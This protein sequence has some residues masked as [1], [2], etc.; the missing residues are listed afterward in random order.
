MV[1]YTEITLG[2]CSLGTTQGIER[3]TRPPSTALQGFQVID[4][5]SHSVMS[6]RVRPIPKSAL[7]HSTTVGDL[8]CY[9]NRGDGRTAIGIIGTPVLLAP[10]QHITRYRSVETGKKPPVLGQERECHSPLGTKPQ[11]RCAG[12]DLAKADNTTKGMNR[13]SQAGLLFDPHQ[14]IFAFTGQPG[15]LCCD[16]ERIE[17][18]FHTS[19]IRFRYALAPWWPGR[20]HSRNEQRSHLGPVSAVGVRRDFQRTCIFSAFSRVLSRNDESMMTRLRRRCLP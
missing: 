7:E 6:G 11:Q 2:R 12:A 13:K 17:C 1:K 5:H 3:F 9:Q 16:V 15:T 19:S 20:Q 14:D 10:E 4:S 18:L 8:R